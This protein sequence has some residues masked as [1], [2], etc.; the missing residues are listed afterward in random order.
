MTDQRYFEAVAQEQRENRLDEGLWLKAMTTADNDR[1]HA[2]A[3][4]VT[5]R[6]EQL[7][8]LHKEQLKVVRSARKAFSTCPQCGCAG[9]FPSRPAKRIAILVG[10][11]PLLGFYIMRADIL[12]V[13]HTIWRRGREPDVSSLPALLLYVL[14]FAGPIFVVLLAARGAVKCPSCDLTFWYDKDRPDGDTVLKSL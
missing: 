11:L 8:Q 9:P 12:M 10:L 13:V 6:V 2:R 5:M 3:L 4:Y 1:E 14:M 7:K